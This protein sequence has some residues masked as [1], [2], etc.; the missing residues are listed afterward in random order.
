MT[1]V[2]VIIRTKKIAENKYESIILDEKEVPLSGSFLGA[3]EE[4]SFELAKNSF[5]KRSK[6]VI[7]FLLKDSLKTKK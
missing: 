3:T 4:E 6:E 7:E 5:E 2:N 1:I